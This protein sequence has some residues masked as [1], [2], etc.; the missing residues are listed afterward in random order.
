[1]TS[2]PSSAVLST[3]LRAHAYQELAEVRSKL[4]LQADRVM[5][6]TLAAIN[7]LARAVHE[8]TR[9]GV[10]IAHPGLGQYHRM[11]P[12]W[13]GLF[14]S[15]EWMCNGDRCGRGSEPVHPTSRVMIQSVMISTLQ[16]NT[17]DDHS[18]NPINPNVV[19][20]RAR[21]LEYKQDSDESRDVDTVTIRSEYHH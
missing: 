21:H 4:S 8:H 2:D 3:P 16:L 10:R 13:M 14:I 6:V 5:A 9:I 1:M 19:G 11:Q 18:R 20:D 15:L 12:L 17:I 7:C